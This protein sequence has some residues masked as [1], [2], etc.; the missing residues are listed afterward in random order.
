MILML[1]SCL[2]CIAVL[3]S[4]AYCQNSES[5]FSYEEGCIKCHEEIDFF[6][7]NFTNEDVHL[8]SGLSCSGCHGGNPN[9]DDADEAMSSKHNFIGI[10]T[11]KEIPN[12]CGKCHSNIDIM[13]K[14][15]PRIQTDQVSQYYTSIHGKK[16]LEGD[17]NVADCID[18]HSSHNILKTTD[19]R[20]SVYALNIPST[21]NKCHGNLEI[22]KQYN[23]KADQYTKYAESVHGIA[24]LKNH[25]TGAPACNDCHGN[26][27]A[28]PPEVESISH[29][30]GTCHLNNMN[31]FNTSSMSKTFS[32]MD[33]HACE[34][35]HCYHGIK[36]SSDEMIGNGNESVCAICHDQ[37][38][39][40]YISGQ[41]IKENLDKLAAS[42]NSADSALLDVTIKGMNDTEIGFVLQEAK[43]KLIQSR[44]AVHS[45]DTS[46]VSKITEEGYVLTLKALD[47][48]DSEMTEYY[49]RREG[50][51][52]TSIIFFVLG[53]SIFFK[54]KYKNSTNNIS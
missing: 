39:P 32:E 47:L 35:C 54:I 27:G 21:C 9:T 36:K 11:K 22:M 16:L 3:N 52:Y 51:I 44:T 26:H 41:V 31:L 37:N 14:Y 49:R 25:D 18:C 13:R 8:Q 29:V 45:F 42:Y 43:Q 38:D 53:L 1:S 28:I 30:C 5:L 2:I 48:A 46:T 7:E 17:I 15:Q 20:S 24:L 23:L 4:N 40:G 19:P 6:P 12:F 33:F 50:F 34:P 10:P